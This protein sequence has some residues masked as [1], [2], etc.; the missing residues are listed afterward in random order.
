MTALAAGFNGVRSGGE[1]FEKEPGEIVFN[2]VR[3]WGGLGFGEY[4]V[5]A[6]NNAQTGASLLGSTAKAVTG[7]TV[8]DIINQIQYGMGPAELVG[9]NLPFY[10]LYRSVPVEPRIHKRVKD[11]SRGIDQALFESLGLRDPK[12]TKMFGDSPFSGKMFGKDPFVEGGKVD[13]EV[14]RTPPNPSSRIDKMT[15]LPYED[16]AGDIIENREDFRLGGL[17]SRGAQHFLRKYFK[18]GIKQED[19]VNDPLYSQVRHI[20]DDME[21]TPDPSVRE[22]SQFIE[23]GKITDG[24]AFQLDE[25][26]LQWRKDSFIEQSEIKDDVILKS[27]SSD[28]TYSSEFHEPVIGQRVQFAQVG[29]ENVPARAGEW[30]SRGKIRVLNSLKYDGDIPDRPFL[31]LYDKEFMNMPNLSNRQKEFLNLRK[32]YEM[33]AAHIERLF[34]AESIPTSFDKESLINE[35]NIQYNKKFYNLLEGLGYDSIQ[36]N[37]S[38][39]ARPRIRTIGGRTGYTFEP[40]LPTA[41]ESGQS[42]RL[43]FSL[44]DEAGFDPAKMQTE[45]LDVVP[46]HADPE[47]AKKGISAREER[48]SDIQ[49]I[50]EPDIKYR[51]VRSDVEYKEFEPLYTTSK[52]RKVPIP[53][54]ALT[55]EYTKNPS[56]LLFRKEQWYPST[57]FEAPSKFEIKAINDL[58]VE[59]RVD[60]IN[61]NSIKTV[62]IQVIKKVFDDGEAFHMVST[63]TD[64][65]PMGRVISIEEA[66]PDLLHSL[67]NRIDLD[68]TDQTKILER[69]KKDMENITQR[70]Y[71][72]IDTIPGIQKQ[73]IHPGLR[74]QE[75]IINAIKINP[76]EHP[77]EF[78]HHP[79]GNN[80]LTEES[81]LFSLINIDADDIKGEFSPEEIIKMTIDSETLRRQNIKLSS[82]MSEKAR[83]EAGKVKSVRGEKRFRT[84]EEAGQDPQ[85]SPLVPYHVMLNR[86]GRPLA[87]DYKI[88]K[89]GEL[90]IIPEKVDPEETKI[91]RAL[92]KRQRERE[93]WETPSGKPVSYKYPIFKSEGVLRKG[94]KPTKRRRQRDEEIS[95]E[96]AGKELA[97]IGYVEKLSVK[98]LRDNPNKVYLFGD[99][100]IGRGKAGQAII[101]DEPNAVGI[102]TKKSPSMDENAFFND[103]EF[104]ENTKAIDDAFNRI[105]EGSDIVVPEAGLGTGLARLES[106]APRTFEY[107]NNKLA[108]LRGAKEAPST[109][110]IYSTGKTGFEDLSNLAPRPFEGPS[111][112]QYYSVEHA[113]Q[114]IKSGSFDKTTYNN[115]KW[116]Q[117]WTKISGGKKAKTE[118]NW[119]VQVMEQMMKASFEQN[120]RAMELLKFTGDSTLTH[121][122][123]KGIWKT[124]F[125]RILMKLRDEG[126]REGKA[127]G[128]LIERYNQIRVS[129]GL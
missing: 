93:G 67:K 30:M 121:T 72:R 37:A 77:T 42:S 2:A 27:T 117:G 8:A 60:F 70:V 111:G 25:Q 91:L 123:D 18:S 103:A 1:E 9:T 43:D 79:K 85:P 65:S 46:L 94:E 55:E 17:V 83:I 126:G 44:M 76:R 23:D 80:P 73:V 14:P 50:P 57:G 11:V 82:E 51:R 39:L 81:R 106:K 64:D 116:E 125:P 101:R 48:P 75:N 47:L 36:Y 3:R 45:E 74:T 99:N 110:N 95:A 58:P 108:E 34:K 49:K 86:P 128:G 59:E 112:R 120:P 105:P 69:L 87:E 24:Q 90:V 56:I 122:Q 33:S 118:D 96:G 68:N 102:P 12:K 97:E 119:N 21:S 4:A 5:N 114:S 20:I 89:K 35:L 113:Y 66:S 62:P 109:I 52:G 16:Q 63:A 31:L 53:A 54:R 88:N 40:I 6:R 104:A 84:G 124:E 92:R 19:V 29:Q 78:W 26:E 129:N 127:T 115:P 98:E 22:H 32:E 61:E 13:R 41:R 38:P 15:G 107:L 71:V 28:P 7:P 10:G 100:L